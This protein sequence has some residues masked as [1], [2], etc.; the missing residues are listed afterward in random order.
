MKAINRTIKLRWF[1]MAT[2]SLLFVTCGIDKVFA[3]SEYSVIVNVANNYKDTG[4]AM[5]DFVGQIYLKHR[6]SWPNQTKAKVYARSANS[7]EHKMFTEKILKMTQTKLEKYWIYFNDQT[8]GDP[9]QEIG[10]DS[11]LIR[12]VMR[13]IGALGVV[14]T[15]K[16][17]SVGNNVKILFTFP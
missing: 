7:P 15:D 5:R 13:D 9:P 6:N 16:A 8:G 12:S 10:A 11:I 4:N 1:Y 3:A 2:V 17:K 14:T